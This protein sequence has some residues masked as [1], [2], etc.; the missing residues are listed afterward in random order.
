MRETRAAGGPSA[1]DGQFSAETIGGLLLALRRRAED[2]PESPGLI[3]NWPGVPEAQMPAACAV[4]RRQGHAVCQVSIPGRGAT[5]RRGWAVGGTIHRAVGPQAARADVFMVEIADP[6][7]VPLARALVERFAEREGAPE[8]V[9]SALA[10]AVTEACSNV[11]MH[12]YLD[13]EV[14]GDLEVRAGRVDS[15][16]V[17]DVRDDGRGMIPRLDSPGLGLG[18]PLI[19]QLTDVVEILDRVDRPGVIVRM[20]FKLETNGASNDHRH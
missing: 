16:L 1:T 13:A 15:M 18:L 12:A 10:L 14:P 6:G 7:A 19:A 17:V 9:R 2:H 5:E 4:L 11:V 20:H 3:A 8:V